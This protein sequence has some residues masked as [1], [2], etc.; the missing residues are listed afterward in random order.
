[1][2]KIKS[3]LNENRLKVTPPITICNSTNL[4]RLT[5]THS[6]LFDSSIS[7]EV[8]SKNNRLTLYCFNFRQTLS[9]RHEKHLNIQFEVYLG[10]HFSNTL[11][12][13]KI[14]IC[15]HFSIRGEN[16][17]YQT[18]PW[19]LDRLLFLAR[20]NEWKL[21]ARI[22]K[23]NTHIHAGEIMFAFAGSLSLSLDRRR[24]KWGSS[25]WI[26]FYLM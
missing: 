10:N 5:S 24:G 17:C 11:K 26:N 13:Q 25:E 20:A 21:F 12:N 14:I 2:F 8:L 19:M 9:W 15:S 3:E 23:H 4:N 22:Y 1:M 6:S 16:I 7:R 18:F